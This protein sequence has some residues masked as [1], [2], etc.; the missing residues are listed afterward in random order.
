[1]KNNYFPK[2][3][4][5]KRMAL[6]KLWQISV[7][8]G[9]IKARFLY[10]LLHF[11]CCSILVWLKYMKFCFTHMLLEEMNILP[12]QIIVDI[13]LDTSPELSK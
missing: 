11:I 8:S 4:I 1:M 5:I 12:F 3:K 2:Q 7:M 13:L 10:L 9:L 6:F